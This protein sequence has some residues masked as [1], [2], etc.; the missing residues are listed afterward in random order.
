MKKQN[1]CLQSENTKIAELVDIP[2]EKWVS[3]VFCTNRNAKKR[4]FFWLWKDFN[5]KI[6]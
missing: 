3:F 1:A 6:T 4:Y 5:A 2:R